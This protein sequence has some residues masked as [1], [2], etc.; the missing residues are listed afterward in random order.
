MLS[1]KGVEKTILQ[2][3]TMA[4]VF[5]NSEVLKYMENQLEEGKDHVRVVVVGE[6]AAGRSPLV[7]LLL[8]K[9]MA[10]EPDTVTEKPKEYE[11]SAKYKGKEYKM[12]I[13][14]TPGF[15]D[16]DEDKEFDTLCDSYLAGCDLMVYC[17]SA[18]GRITKELGNEFKK[19]NKARGEELWKKT[20]IV[21]TRADE[22]MRFKHEAWEKALKRCVP[23]ISESARFANS[24][25]ENIIFKAAVAVNKKASMCW[26]YVVYSYSDD[27][28]GLSA[29]VQFF[30]TLF[31]NE[32]VCKMF[33]TLSV[34]EIATKLPA[35]LGPAVLYGF[36]SLGFGLGS[37]AA[38]YIYNKYYK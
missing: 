31:Q 27:S 11:L 16:P 24:G 17:I 37:V 32:K 29:L 19:L 38:Y 25:D 34:A 8:G 20:L 18:I 26:L 7:K 21:F 10:K 13:V 14:D 35:V 28:T 15:G 3:V 4:T 36:T 12:T 9:K 33:S 2:P 5:N 1:Q 23:E 6:V 22:N 30:V